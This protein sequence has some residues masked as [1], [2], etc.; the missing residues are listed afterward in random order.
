MVENCCWILES[1]WVI[2]INYYVITV[3]WIWLHCVKVV[4]CQGGTIHLGEWHQFVSKHCV[5]WQFCAYFFS[6]MLHWNHKPIH[7]NYFFNASDFVFMIGVL[8]LQIQHNFKDQPLNVIAV[9]CVCQ[10]LKMGA[11]CMLFNTFIRRTS[12]L[13]NIQNMFVIF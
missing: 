10:N 4:H 12:G 3:Q 9:A 5:P 13:N 1:T 8:S 11:I 6:H 2:A 7:F